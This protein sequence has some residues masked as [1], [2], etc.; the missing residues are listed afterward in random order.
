MT[1]TLCTKTVTQPRA[2]TGTNHTHNARTGKTD[3][4]RGQCSPVPGPHTRSRRLISPTDPLL[5]LLC[6]FVA[7]GGGGDFYCFYTN[8]MLQPRLLRSRCFSSASAGTTTSTRHG[9]EL[10]MRGRRMGPSGAR[11]VHP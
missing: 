10:P 9:N 2:R 5:S 6:A 7:F 3:T 11:S 4:K 1:N 8:R